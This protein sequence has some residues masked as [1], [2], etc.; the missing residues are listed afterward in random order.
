MNMAYSW[1][2]LWIVP[3]GKLMSQDLATPD[4]VVSR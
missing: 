4:N 2:Q 1:S 3:S